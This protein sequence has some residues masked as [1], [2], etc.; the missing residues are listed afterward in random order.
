MS[1]LRRGPRYPKTGMVYDRY[2]TAKGKTTECANCKAKIK[3]GDRYSTVDLQ[4]D[5][6]RGND[7][8]VEVCKLC[9]K[10]PLNVH[11]LLKTLSDSGTEG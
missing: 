10:G 8:V 6:F 7:E 4:L 2:R 11:K 1:R 3:P 9:S 5:W